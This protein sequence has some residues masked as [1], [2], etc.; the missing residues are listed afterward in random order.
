MVDVLGMLADGVVV[1][2]A[3]VMTTV[4][5]GKGVVVRPAPVNVVLV[6]GDRLEEG[7]ELAEAVVLEV[8]GLV[9]VGLPEVELAG[10]EG[11]LPPVKYP[12][13]GTAFDGSLSL[14][15]PQGIA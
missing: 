15:I 8:P 1:A 5:E 9:E 10:G 13:G 11:V 14:P 3:W 2:V 6:L 4:V 7:V 12:G